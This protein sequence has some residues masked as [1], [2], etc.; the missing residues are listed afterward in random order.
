MKNEI[1]PARGFFFEGRRRRRRRVHVCS[2][3]DG[4]RNN[5]A[6]IQSVDTRTNCR[7]SRWPPVFPVLFPENTFAGEFVP[8]WRASSTSTWFMDGVTRRFPSSFCFRCELLPDVLS[9]RITYEV[10]GNRSGQGEWSWNH[11]PFRTSPFCIPYFRP[12][13]ETEFDRPSFLRS[14]CQS[15]HSF[16]ARLEKIRSIWIFENSSVNLF[17]NLMKQFRSFHSRVI[18]FHTLN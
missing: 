15:W 18:I 17:I 12:R 2:T 7:V 8:A 11:I 4:P 9:I 6:H 14:L 16:V 3:L 10:I 13:I 5:R 1:R